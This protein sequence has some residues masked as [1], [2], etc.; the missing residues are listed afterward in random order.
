MKRASVIVFCCLLYLAASVPIA[1]AG[2]FAL[3]EWSNRGVAM[4]TTGYA[5]AGDASVIATNPALMTQHEG[6]EVLAGFVAITPTS[7]V[8]INDSKYQTR[9]KTHIVPHAYYTQ[10]VEDDV[11]LGIGTFTRFGLG[12]SYD[13]GWPG[14]AELNYV[15]LKSNSI[16]PTV[17]FKFSDDFSMAV[18]VELI[19]G[20]I[21]IEKNNFTANTNGWGAGGNIGL[22]YKFDEQWS[23]GFTYR[24]PIHLMTQGSATYVV[25]GNTKSDQC[26]EATLPSSFTLGV[27]FKPTEDWS[28]EF[29]TIFTRWETLDKMVY[30]GFLEA[31]DFLDY[32]NVWRF[33]LGSEYWATDWLALRFGYVYDQTP[34][35][36]Y[37]AS[38]MLPANDRQL[39]STGLGFKVNDFKIDWSFMYIFTKERTGLHIGANNAA[40]KNGRTWISGLSVGYEF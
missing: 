37:E 31:T 19:K 22:H 2:G 12:T 27:G 13:V 29:D 5:F 26:I 15:N 20:G 24:T 36:H 11:W 3:Y 39:F 28:I 1:Q 34:T 21:Q 6:G 8:Y 18:G 7:D 23:A 10:Q 16:N 17:A 33:Q 4:G 32:K 14:A 30:S 38:Y 35:V 9:R 25:S 40:F